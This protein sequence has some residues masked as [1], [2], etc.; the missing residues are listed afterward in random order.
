MLSAFTIENPIRG[1]DPP[2]S[3][4]PPELTVLDF[5]NGVAG[6][7]KASPSPPAQ[8]FHFAI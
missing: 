3:D 1:F 7:T 4:T 6:L 2:S 5:P 8:A